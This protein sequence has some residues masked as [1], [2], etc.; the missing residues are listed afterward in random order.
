MTRTRSTGAR[1]TP[2]SPTA[3]PS[4]ST[5]P[6]LRPRHGAGAGAGAT[7]TLDYGNDLRVT[8]EIRDEGD[9]GFTFTMTPSASAEGAPAIAVLRI[10]ARTSGDPER[11]LLRSRRVGGLGRPARQAAPDADRGRPRDRERQ[12]RGARPGAVPHRHA[13]LGAVRRERVASAPSTSR[14]RTRPW[15]Q[16]TFAVDPRGGSNGAGR[17]SAC[18]VRRRRTRSTSMK[19]LLRVTG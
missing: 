12:Q 15:S 13:R 18:A 4:A 10:R 16:A 9:A 2:A 14:A 3:L 17:R 8:V 5:P 1:A 6:P 7:V 19:Q 11:G